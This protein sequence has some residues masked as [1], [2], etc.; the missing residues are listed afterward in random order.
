MN[1]FLKTKIGPENDS[2]LIIHSS[3]NVTPDLPTHQ[4]EFWIHF[5]AFL[6]TLFYCIPKLHIFLKILVALNYYKGYMSYI[7]FGDILV[8][9]VS[10][11]QDLAILLHIAVFHLLF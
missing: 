10:H 7:I 9:L 1:P 4:P 11:C 3:T 8:Y 6:S 5:L 2:H